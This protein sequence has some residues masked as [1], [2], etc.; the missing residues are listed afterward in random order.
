MADP[1]VAG[2]AEASEDVAGGTDD[3]FFDHGG[4]GGSGEFSVSLSLSDGGVGLRNRAVGQ[5]EEIFPRGLRPNL[6]MLGFSVRAE[7]RTLQ[8]KPGWSE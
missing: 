7:A 6:D 1:L 2:Q 3:A 8:L 4:H 5:L